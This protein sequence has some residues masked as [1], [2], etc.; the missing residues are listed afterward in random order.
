MQ[1]KGV[2][3]RVQ[4]LGRELVVCDSFSSAVYLETQM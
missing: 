1:E 4:R 3:V 2:R